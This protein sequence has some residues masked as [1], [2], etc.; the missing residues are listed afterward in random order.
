M[1]TEFKFRDVAGYAYIQSNILS[2]VSKAANESKN[3]NL[4][5]AKKYKEFEEIGWNSKFI[6]EVIFNTSTCLYMLFLYVVWGRNNDS[7][8]KKMEKTKLSEIIQKD[9][10][11][12]IDMYHFSIKLR[13]AL[14]HYDFKFYKNDDETDYIKIYNS[15]LCTIEEL[16]L[17][18]CKEVNEILNFIKEQPKD[19]KIICENQ[20][21]VSKHYQS[22]YC[23]EFTFE[24]FIKLTTYYN[25][26][27]VKN[28]LPEQKKTE[29][30]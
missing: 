21:L 10:E 17:N 14:S 9:L 23:I 15:E 6:D 27:F 5:I 3:F 18:E 12:D 7:L 4:E 16:N 1:K 30:D 13:N 11:E 8:F 26:F 29:N 20:I 2:S 19:N 22:T 28:V 24:E 25:N